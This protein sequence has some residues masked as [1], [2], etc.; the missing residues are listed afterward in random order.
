MP[1]VR[2]DIFKC[3]AQSLSK[4]KKKKTQIEKQYVFDNRTF[5]LDTHLLE[6]MCLLAAFP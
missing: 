2:T 6:T 5:E 4:K 3:Y 1:F